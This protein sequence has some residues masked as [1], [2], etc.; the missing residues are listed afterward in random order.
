[1]RPWITLALL[2]F[3]GLGQGRPCVRLVPFQAE[4]QV[5]RSGLQLG[6]LEIELRRDGEQAYH[7]SGHTRPGALVRLF[8]SD[9]I[10]ETSQGRI[11]EGRVIP[12][13]YLHRLQRVGEPEKLTRLEF[14]WSNRKVWS[15][16]DGTRWAQRIDPGGQD[17]LS[18]QLALRLDLAAGREQVSYRVADGGRIKTYHF[19]VVG[20]ET[21][22]LPYGR[23]GCLRVRRSKDDQAP[24][25]TIWVAPTLD[26]LPVKIERKRRSGRY[27]MELSTLLQ[28]TQEGS[29]R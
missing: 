29:A 16:S 2:L 11:E 19:R 9:E 12:H 6:T 13:S 1:M 27:R 28:P 23:L 22:E 15:E 10:F 26:Y 25:Y 24:D 21:I 14:D 4:F 20:R 17:K 7:Y 5:S 3:T 8:Y 18:M